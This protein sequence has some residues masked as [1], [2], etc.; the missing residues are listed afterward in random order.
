MQVQEA[1]NNVSDFVKKAD[2]DDKQKIL[3]KKVALNKAKTCRI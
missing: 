3:N 1:K 2:F